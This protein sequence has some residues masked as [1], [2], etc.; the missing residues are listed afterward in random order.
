MDRTRRT[1][2][3]FASLARPPARGTR[4]PS[5]RRV[6]RKFRILVTDVV[7]SLRFCC[8]RGDG[9]T[10]LLSFQRADSEGGGAI[11]R[12]ARYSREMTIEVRPAELAD[13]RG[14]AAVHVQAW[15][16]AYAHLLA[17]ETL[18]RLSIEQREL[19]WRENL[20]STEFSTLVATDGDEIVGFATSG[21]GR[22]ADS[23]RE[24]ELPSIY[25]LAS[26]YGLGAGQ[27][28]LDVALG[29]RPAYLWVADDNPRARAFY[30]RNGFQ[31]DG[32]TKVGQLG[33]TDI[34]EARLVR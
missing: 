22:D 16:E 17:A 18:A 20:A 11:A 29:G 24:L 12:Q 30:A 15:R 1:V 32:V 5:I 14:I 31:P 21:A 28:L 13:A 9:A 27:Q 7:V 34:L 4:H 33:G 8:I 10:N 19:R 23:P 26:H 3:P 2:G 6:C 25:V